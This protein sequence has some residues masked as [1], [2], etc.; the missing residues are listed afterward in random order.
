L[1]VAAANVSV[2]GH[3]VLAAARRPPDSAAAMVEVHAE[4]W[5]YNFGP[6]KLLQRIRSEDGTVM[7]IESLG[8]GY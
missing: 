7:Q 6:D 8:Y 3:E 2:A 1:L 4:V 5:L